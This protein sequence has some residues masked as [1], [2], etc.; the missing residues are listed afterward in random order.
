MKLWMVA[1]LIGAGWM[2]LAYSQ[3]HNTSTFE[4]ASTTT[5]TSNYE[6]SKPQTLQEQEDEMW[7]MGGLAFAVAKICRLRSSEW[8]YRIEIGISHWIYGERAKGHW[9]VAQQAAADKAGNA[10]H[11][12][13]IKMY[14]SKPAKCQELLGPTARVLD[15]LDNLDVILTGGYH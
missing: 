5:S 10:A 12:E 8:D 14:V 11:A 3:S 4:V 15:K 1:G 7:R 2:G 13:V 6:P 9:T